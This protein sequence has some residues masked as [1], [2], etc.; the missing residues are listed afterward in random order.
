[1]KAQKG[2]T[3]IELMIVV[4][5][6]GILAAIAIPAYQNYIARAEANTGLQA[7]APLKTAVE[8]QFS[9]GVGGASTTVQ[10]LGSGATASP[11]GTITATFTSSGTG[12]LVFVFDRQASPRVKDSRITLTRAND[13]TW[14]CTSD[15]NT[16]FRP[17]GC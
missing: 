10:N 4:A 5:I 3:L 17:R 13:G 11:L 6:I 14:T 1:M 9:R 16:D 7:I 8:D 15:V 12:T 2:F